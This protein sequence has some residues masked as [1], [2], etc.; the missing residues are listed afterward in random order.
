MRK[1]R[2]VSLVFEGASNILSW[3]FTKKFRF[4]FD[5]VPYQLDNVS[6]RKI[7]NYYLTGLNVIFP[8]PKPFGWPVYMQIEP[9]NMC[10]LH[11]PLC[12]TGSGESEKKLPKI[13]LP[14]DQFKRIID[15]LGDT[16]ILI[17]LW[18]IGEPLI[19]YEIYEMIRYAKT[20]NIIVVLST[21]GLLLDQKDHIQQLL[22]CGLDELI[23]AVDGA[24]EE[25]YKEYRIGGDFN[26]LLENIKKL[27]KAKR[28]KGAASPRIEMRFMVTKTN[29]HEI[30]KI[31]ELAHE[32]GVD[33]LTLRT[34][35]PHEH[36]SM[37]KNI[38]LTPNDLDYLPKNPKYQVYAYDSKG[39]RINRHDSYFCHFQYWHPTVHATGNVTICEQDYWG[40][41]CYGNLNQI[42]SIREIWKSKRAVELRRKKAENEFGSFEVC[43]RCFNADMKGNTWTVERIQIKK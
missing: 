21:N 31:K 24:S 34:C 25:T 29:E 35:A 32:L 1:S 37:R 3:F 30:P 18:G 13:N 8:R 28:E 14:L 16:V 2:K 4:K 43:T 9:S 42:P 26:H 11:C 10:N 41:A 33:E 22:S 39:V 12:P 23:L 6:F 7:F 36:G 15:E 5:Y 17:M 27:V 40:S 20:K 38:Y 19:N